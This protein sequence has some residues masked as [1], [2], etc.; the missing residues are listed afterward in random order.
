LKIGFEV[1]KIGFGV[2]KIGFGVLKTG[3]G[4]LKIGFGVLKI[5]GLHRDDDGTK[6][7]WRGAWCG[8][9]HESL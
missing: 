8:R 9:T 2:L 1:L 5:G 4:V 3:F 7:S 6:E